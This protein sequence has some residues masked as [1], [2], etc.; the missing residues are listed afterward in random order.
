MQVDANDRKTLAR[1]HESDDVALFLS[2][3]ARVR[4]DCLGLLLEEADART[5]ILMQGR[6]QALNHTLGLPAACAESLRE[7]AEET[8]AD[9]SGV[10]DWLRQRVRAFRI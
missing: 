3:L 5:L 6:V 4:D 7:E 9:G 2:V 1:L 8:E 10:R